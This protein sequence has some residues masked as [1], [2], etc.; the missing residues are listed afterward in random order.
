[1]KV[2]EASISVRAWYR[3]RIPV[4][5]VMFQHCIAQFHVTN[6]KV[7]NTE[8]CECHCCSEVMSLLCLLCQV[9]YSTGRQIET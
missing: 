7:R 2:T 5:Y 4:P 9:S 8:V 1:M 3:P 6:R